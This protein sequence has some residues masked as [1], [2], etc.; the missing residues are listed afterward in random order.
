MRSTTILFVGPVLSFCFPLLLVAQAAT[1]TY[2]PSEK[3]CQLTGET[4]WS[5]GM[6]TTTQTQQFGMK[7]TDLGYPVEHNGRLALLFGDTRTIPELPQHDAF[8][9]PDDAVG[10]ITSRTPPTPN[11]CT[12]LEINHMAE[13]VGMERRN[14]LLSPRVI[15]P[16]PQGFF[17]RHY[18]E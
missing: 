15:P 18:R 17:N 10:W 12:D 7:G 2:G 9:P 11:Q 4:D 14:V 3:V 5:T 8:G 1:L 6:P 13:G 16:I